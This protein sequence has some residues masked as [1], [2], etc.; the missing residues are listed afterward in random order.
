MRARVIGIEVLVDV[1]DQVG[2]RAVE[3]GNFV[4]SIG[5]AVGD[6]GSGGCPVV[7]G[8]ENNL[9]KSTELIA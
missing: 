5:R 3:V 1:K 4:K 6:E 7:S 9:E 2:S 8:K